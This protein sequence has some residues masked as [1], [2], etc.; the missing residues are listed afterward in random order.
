M[1][2]SPPSHSTRTTVGRPAT[3]STAWSPRSTGSAPRSVPSARVARSACTGS[4]RTAALGRQP[5][6][7]SNARTRSWSACA[8]RTTAWRRT[9]QVAAGD[10]W[11]RRSRRWWMRRRCRCAARRSSCSRISQRAR[12]SARRCWR[13]GSRKKLRWT[14]TPALRTC[15]RRLLPIRALGRPPAGSHQRGQMRKAWPSSPMPPL[16]GFD[17]A[18]WSLLAS[19]SRP[20]GLQPTRRGCREEAARSSSKSMTSRAGPRLPSESR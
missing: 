14:A 12:G 17:L 15:P 18:R 5:W 2:A 13:S 1:S 7:S 8:T 11:A 4:P 3:A 10:V 19:S 16:S 6:S 20:G 9:S